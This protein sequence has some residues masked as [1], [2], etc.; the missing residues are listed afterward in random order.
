MQEIELVMPE[1]GESVTDATISNWLVKEGDTISFDQDILEVSTDKVDTEIPSPVNG[2]IVKFLHQ[3]GDVVEVGKPLAMIQVQDGEQVQPSPAISS[4]PENKEQAQTPAGASSDEKTED[5]LKHP[6]IP[7]VPQPSTEPTPAPVQSDDRFFSPLVRSIAQE[8]GISNDE[9]LQIQG[10]GLEGRVTKDDI[11]SYVSKRS[12]TTT[13]SPI[14]KGQANTTA[15]ALSQSKPA[16]VSTSTASTPG[17]ELVEMDKMR[18]LIADHMVN[19]VQTSP[20]ATLFIEADVTN[21]V[22]WRNQHKKDFE[23]R[24]GQKLTFTPL[25]IEAVTNAIKLYPGVNVSVVDQYKIQY[26]KHINIGMATALPNGNLIV[27]VVKKCEEKS[28]VALAKSV[29][30]LA[31]RAR[32]NAL[33]PDDT[34]GGSFTLTNIG[35]FDNLMGTPIINQPQAAILAVGAI[36]KRPVVIE[37]NQGDVIAIRQMMYLSLTMDHRVIDGAL[38]GAFLKQVVAELEQ[39]DTQRTI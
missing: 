35:T 24:E 9:L 1:M 39:W 30:D 6:D 16:Q 10:T 19:S 33:K 34:Q 20:H 31:N 11:I 12:S 37:T 8:E 26:K 3:P 15:Q 25:F 13:Q 29:N 14:S 23:Q 27:P 36:K 17:D 18:R 28:L 22:R 4:Q 7:H 38:G 2:V 32:T 5:E 21:L